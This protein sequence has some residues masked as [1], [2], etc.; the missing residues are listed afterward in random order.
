[1][2]NPKNYSSKDDFMH[3]C[4]PM[5]KK[6]GKDKSHAQSV[7]V[8]LSMWRNKGKKSK[9]KSAVEIAELEKQG[10]HYEVDESLSLLED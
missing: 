5:R 10:N 1:M 3:A 2:P 6:E 4:V 7:A 8:C 9:K